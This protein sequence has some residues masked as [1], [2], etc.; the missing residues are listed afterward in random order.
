M[1]RVIPRG[2][3]TPSISAYSAP[4][5]IS[6]HGSSPRGRGTLKLSAD[7]DHWLRVIP[8]WAGNTSAGVSASPLA[9]GHPR[10]G[11]EHMPAPGAQQSVD[12]SSPRGRGTLAGGVFDLRSARVIPAW[13]G[14]TVGDRFVDSILAGHPRVG[15]EHVTTILR[16]QRV[17]GS[18]PRGRGTLPS[19]GWWM[20][21]RRVIP[22]WAGN[23]ILENLY[24]AYPAG[25]PR[26]G[27][28]HDVAGAFLGMPPG[29]PAWAGN[30]SGVSGQTIS[31][32]G[33]PRVGGEHRRR[34]ARRRP[35][36]GSSPRGRGTHC[37]V[38]PI[39][40]AER[41]IPAWAGNTRKTR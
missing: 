16:G 17:G 18:S 21:S 32:P 28:E 6:P 4:P 40:E 31:R 13:A 30:T 39:P 38:Q 15:G 36:N 10:V 25:H 33:H 22:A 41:V 8:A 20:R 11:G 1:F 14:N 29:H 5:E 12:G 24:R 23:T 35:G 2:R 34:H 37:T 7:P 3:G 27:G 26:V 19:D 9:S